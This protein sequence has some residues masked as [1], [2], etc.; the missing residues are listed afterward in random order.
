MVKANPSMWE[1][2]AENSDGSMDVTLTAPD[3]PWLA[4]MTMSFAH[5][6]KVLEPQELQDMI[7]E[8]AQATAN[9]YNE[10]N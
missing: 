3:L 1:S 2:V 6:A 5:W 9:S 7:R 4:S 10:S 8:W